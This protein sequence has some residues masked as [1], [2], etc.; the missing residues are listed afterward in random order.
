MTTLSLTIHDP[1]VVFITG[2]NLAVEVV[3]AG[4]R[5]SELLCGTASNSPE[6]ANEKQASGLSAAH[7]DDAKSD[8]DRNPVDV[9]L[10]T[11]GETAP[12]SPSAPADAVT[13][14][15]AQ[16]PAVTAPHSHQQPTDSPEADTAGEV[17]AHAASPADPIT[18]KPAHGPCDSASDSI[19][20]EQPK[21]EPALVAP[22]GAL[23]LTIQ[24]VGYSTTPPAINPHCAHP[25]TCQFARSMASCSA[26]ANAAAKARVAA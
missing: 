22:A 1:S 24:E 3:A 21:N 12:H 6:R 15:Q 17:V 2:E 5:F 9:A 20:R 10:V 19:A 8:S 16:A 23:G 14:P 7:A 18:E 26:C 13:V 4:P 11:A 25:G